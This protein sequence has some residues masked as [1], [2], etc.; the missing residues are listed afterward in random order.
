MSTF[1]TVR[2][3]QWRDAQLFLL[4][5]RD[6][7]QRVEYLAMQNY[8]QVAQAITDMV[9]RGAPAIGIAAAYGMALAARELQDGWEWLPLMAQAGEHLKAARPTAVNLAWAVQQQL[10]ALHAPGALANGAEPFALMLAG[11]ERILLEDVAANR[12]IGS[13]GAA[14]LPEQGGV[15]THCNT[16]SLATGGYGTALGIIR[17]AVEQGKRIQVYADET[18]PWLQGAR[19]TAWELQQDGIPVKLVVDS[20]AA[21]LMAAGKVQAVV[22]GADRIAANGDVANKIG[23]YG[24]AVLAR[25]HGI[26][27]LVAAPMSTVDPATPNGA[28]IDIEQRSAEEVTCFRGLPVAPQGTAAENPAFDIAPAELVSA[29]ITEA[30]VFAAPFRFSS[31]PAGEKDRAIG[32]SSAFQSTR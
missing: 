9:V 16:G 27:F 13:L 10:D 22:V 24:L 3:V 6:L 2:A 8:R 17:A 28:A 26:P 5:Q 4:D 23:T 12:R 32:Y 18:R 30:G 15:L 19:L 20:A 7:P 21:S 25:Y 31:G 11:A 14:F 29:I 1:D